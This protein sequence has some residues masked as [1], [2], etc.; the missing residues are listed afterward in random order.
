MYIG[1]EVLV[2]STFGQPVVRILLGGG[3][4]RAII[5]RREAFLRWQG[6]G[7]EPT[8]IQVPKE[9]IFEY[10][11]QLFEAMKAYDEML[12]SMPEGLRQLWDKAKPL[13]A[14]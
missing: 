9:D 1:K 10:D 13:I 2:R 4:G 12:D 3:D 6:Q 5:C 8:G 11:E 7:V 14:G